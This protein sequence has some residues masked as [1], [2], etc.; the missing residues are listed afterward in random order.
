MLAVMKRLLIVP[1]LLWAGMIAQAQTESPVQPQLSSPGSGDE[2]INGDIIVVSDASPF[3][4]TVPAENNA[5]RRK[6]LIK[7]GTF[8][9]YHDNGERLFTTNIKKS[10][11]QGVWKSWYPDGT[12]CDS[13]RFV[14]D[15]PD[16][17]WRGWYPDG[18]LRYIWHFSSTKYFS[19]KSEM[20][21]QPKV[22]FFRI[23]QLPLNEAI[24]YYKT[25]YIFGQTTRTPSVMFRSKTLEHKTFDPEHIKKKV[26]RNTGTLSYIPPFPECLFHGVFASYYS[27][28]RVREEGMYINGMKDGLW[29]EYARDGNKSRGSYHHGRKTGEW[30]TYD[31]KGK[32]LTMTHFNHT[33]VEVYSH[34]F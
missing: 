23:A 11:M 4:E 33:G 8:E 13:G 16:G 3:A 21:N 34:E 30:R 25:D 19:L 2:T 1:V 9:G 31:E 17:E 15:V 10:R 5:F 24:Q 29:E 20:S 26:E 12:I 18:K 32:L 22:K 14:K 6:S 7:N 27:D 28:G